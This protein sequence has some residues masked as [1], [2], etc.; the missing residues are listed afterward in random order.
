MLKF[1]AD[2]MTHEC[3]DIAVEHGISGGHVGNIL[4]RVAKFRGCP[5]AIRWP[6]IY[7]PCVYGLDAPQR[8]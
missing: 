6:R 5:S 7:K 1:Q 4:K 8:Y 3:V 2:D